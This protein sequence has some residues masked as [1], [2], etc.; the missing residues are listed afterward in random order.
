[1]LLRLLKRSP[2]QQLASA[3]L[4]RP[5]PPKPRAFFSS[6]FRMSDAPSSA[7]AAPA[8]APVVDAAAAPAKGKDGKPRGE[9]KEKKPKGDLVAGMAALELDPAPAYIDSRIE[10]FDKLFAEQTARIA[11]EP[12]ESITITLPD[13]GVK[14]ATSWETTPF[15]IALGISKGLA[16]KTVIAKVRLQRSLH[17]FLHSRFLVPEHRTDLHASLQV[18]G[19]LWDL[20]RPFEKSA[21][22]QL[23][24]FD[25]EDGS[26]HRHYSLYCMLTYAR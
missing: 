9:K 20:E 4:R 26:S 12:R 11:A 25:S 2:L 18:D 16:D 23:F 15:Q 8:S 24:D 17:L 6:A 21:T 13:G 19:E 1:M 22:L 5:S 14:E 7:A 10:M 3:S